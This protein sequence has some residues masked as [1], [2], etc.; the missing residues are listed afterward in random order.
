ARAEAD[1]RG[2]ATRAEILA[3]LGPAHQSPRAKTAAASTGPDPAFTDD[4]EAVG[5]RFRYDAGVSK[6]RQIPETMGTGLGLLDYDGDGWLDIYATQGC[7]FPPGPR[8]PAN[9]DR[10]FHNRGDGTFEDATVR[11]GIAALPG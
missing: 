3:E 11:A 2:A 9:G 10:L 8:R 5:L 1:R 7:P 6:E 4:A